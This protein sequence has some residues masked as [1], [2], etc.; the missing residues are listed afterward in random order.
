[1]RYWARPASQE[2]GTH[3]RPLLRA[4]DI[5]P[6]PYAYLLGAYLGDG[7]LVRAKDSDVHHLRI[8]CDE[9]YPKVI[10]EIAAAMSAVNPRHRVHV[11]HH[12]VHRLAIVNAYSAHWPLLL[13]Q[14]GP[15][16]KHERPIALTD[17]QRVVTTA[18][19]QAFIR[20]LI[21]SDGCRFIARQRRGDRTYCYVRYA[22]SNRSEDIKA[23]F[24]EHLNLLGIPW[25]R[26]NSKDIQIARREGVEALDAFVGPKA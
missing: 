10:D 17:W 6:A 2:V 4:E 1:V 23:I 21:H 12:P 3:K 24:C 5:P 25:T 20:G 18:H 9:R 8:Y 14:A 16:R 13:P 26:P 7:Y 15:G 22:F 19:P 11:L